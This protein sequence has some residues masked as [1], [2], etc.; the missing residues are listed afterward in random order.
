M[1][2][3]NG[4]NNPYEKISRDDVVVIKKPQ[5]NLQIDFTKPI[6]KNITFSY[7]DDDNEIIQ[8]QWVVD[9]RF[10]QKPNKF[11]SI[12][13]QL[14]LKSDIELYNSDFTDLSENQEKL[15][16]NISTQGLNI[17]F[18]TKSRAYHTLH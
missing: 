13:K 15:F 16:N 2:N 11:D 17:F 5:E 14:G 10:M 4:G 9:I 18:D 8:F 6:L 1:G 12:H 7:T 3:I